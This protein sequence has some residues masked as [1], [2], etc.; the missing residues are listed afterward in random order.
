[1]QKKAEED[2]KK[3]EYVASYNKAAEAQM[4]AEAA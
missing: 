4:M 1:V 3:A 2:I